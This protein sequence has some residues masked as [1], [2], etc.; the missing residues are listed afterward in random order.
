MS[1]LEAAFAMVAETGIAYVGCRNSNHLGALAPYGLKACERGYVMI[2]GTN[3]STTIAPWGGREARLGNNPLSI[4]APCPK[5]PHFL[6]DMAMSVAAR[7]KIRTARDEG[8]SIPQGWAVD[9]AGK[10]TT[11]PVPALGGFLLPSGAHQ[12]TGPSPEVGTPSGFLA[13]GPVP[14][15]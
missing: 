15:N 6:L 3:A 7:G 13:G 2:A 10:P 11:A 1:A 12:G 8:S 9:A 14:P 4:A 5:P